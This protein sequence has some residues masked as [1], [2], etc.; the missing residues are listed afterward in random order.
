MQKEEMRFTFHGIEY[1]QCA[2]ESAGFHIIQ[3][4]YERT[5]SYGHGTNMG[6]AALL[7]ASQQLESYLSGFG[8]PGEAGVYTAPPLVFDT[9]QEVDALRSIQQSFTR[10]FELNALPI[11]IGGEHTVTYGGLCAAKERYGRVGVIQ[12]DAH[13]DLRHSYRGST[14]SHACVMRRAVQDLS[15]PLMQFGIRSLSTEE[16]EAR[17]MFL[18]TWIDAADIHA[19]WP[20]TD[21]SLPE[22]FPEHIYITFDVDGLDSSLMPA[23]GTPEPGGLF[24][25]QA[26]SILDVVT[27]GRTIIAADVVE[28]APEPGMHHCDYTAAKLVYTLLGLM[29]RSSRS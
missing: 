11:M 19:T 4:P 1:P 26:M 20:T 6:P 22:D 12:F 14:W 13:A 15:L 17:K 27:R 3:A 10:A 8:Y 23:T 21:L 7:E 2:E 16:L 25:H 24:W 29:L 5:V 9:E 18:V 28:L